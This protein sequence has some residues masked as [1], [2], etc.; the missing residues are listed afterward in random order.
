MNSERDHLPTPGGAGIL[1][2][3]L[4][5][6]FQLRAADGSEI[7]IANKRARTILAMLC[8]AP[9]EQLDRKYLSKL[10]WPGRFEAQARASLRQCL[11]AL[12]KLFDPLD[13]KALDVS[14]SRIC[15]HPGVITT[16]LEVLE[17]ALGEGRYSEACTLLRDI[18]GN[19]LLDHVHFGDDFAQWLA[20]HR[21]QI[22]QRLQAAIDAALERLDA[23]GRGGQREELLEAYLLHNPGAAAKT[24]FAGHD[25]KIRLAV[26]PFEQFDAMGGQF[27]LADGVVDELLTTLGRVPQLLVSGRTSS[28]HFRDTSLTL[29]EIAEALHVT[30]LIE[31][32]V[33]RQHDAIRINVRLIDGATGFE[34][35]SYRYD[36]DMEDIF[37]SRDA[38]ALAVTSG[39]C[40][41]LEI[42]P[43]PSKR[44][45]MTASRDAYRLYL[46]G[47]ALTTRG[48]GTDVLNK[49]AELLQEALAIDP[50]FAECWTALAEAYLSIAALTPTLDRA[51]ASER[52]AKCA[53]R[54]ID[55][56]PAQGHARTMLGILQWTKNDV[57]G[58]LDLAFESYRLEPENSSV[59]LRLG[60][61]LLYIGR[62][63]EA[64][65]F[66]EEAVHRDPLNGRSYAMLSAAHL[67]LGDVDAAIAAGQRM[68][69]LG[70][71]TMWLA[72]ATAA[73]GDRDRA[74]E[75]YRQT[76]LLMNTVIFPPAGTEPMAPEVMDAYWHV[77]AKGVCSGKPEDRELYC[78]TLDGLHATML[79]PNDTTITSP[80]IWMG[81][82]EMVFKTIGQQISPANLFSLMSLWTDIE[83]IRQIRLHPDFLAFAENIGM[84]AAWEKYGWPDLLPQPEIQIVEHLQVA[85]AQV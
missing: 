3:S 81:Y 17:S 13:I 65:P 24:A 73:S 38:A 32:S 69:D 47:C 19:R 72:V 77:A 62:T 71:P 84:V 16:D 74:V 37:A 2:A 25:G 31:G 46:Q 53:Q 60:S 59:A 6:L 28:S 44:R 52:T 79:D 54:A 9:G 41:A 5:G 48:I 14:R 70:F 63:R 50:Q 58:A 30:H 39:L 76:R 43:G 4:F 83:P 82:A 26:L 45:K 42:D 29:P 55:L 15:L 78:R 40:A 8:L 35:W 23:G 7:A 67:S 27:L 85:Q 57:V 11:L 21:D 56:D 18:G 22:D 33:Q 68:A 10:L 51:A 64:L 36:G 80:A 1:R 12:G 20:I 75:Q 34:K 49:A 66:I 61:F